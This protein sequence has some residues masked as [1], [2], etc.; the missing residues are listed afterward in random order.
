MVQRFFHARLCAMPLPDFVMYYP[1]GLIHLHGELDFSE[2]KFKDSVGFNVPEILA[3]KVIENW[4][5]EIDVYLDLIIK[6][7][8]R[9]LRL[10]TFM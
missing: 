5:M 9:Y 7:T 8:I 4:D 2:N 6:A 10:L 3:L 1:L